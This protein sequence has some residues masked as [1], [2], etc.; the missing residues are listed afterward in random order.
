MPHWKAK[1]WSKQYLN[2]T[3]RTNDHLFFLLGIKIINFIFLQ[4]E[5]TILNMIHT[6]MLILTIVEH[7][8]GNVPLGYF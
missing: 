2:A 8:K 1:L 3:I 4:D 6:T 7:W 5:I